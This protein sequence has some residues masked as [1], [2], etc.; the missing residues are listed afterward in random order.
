MYIRFKPRSI[1][2]L[3]N[4][5]TL[6]ICSHTQIVLNKTGC[7]TS[8]WVLPRVWVF[9]IFH[10]LSKLCEKWKTKAKLRKNRKKTIHQPVN[11]V[12]SPDWLVEIYTKY[13][14]LVEDFVESPDN[15]ELELP[16]QYSL[17]DTIEFTPYQVN[18]RG[19]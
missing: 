11:A 14:T 6:N 4:I 7:L 8:V 19:T 15:W 12:R 10:F 1:F 18:T 13:T 9:W 2:I 3:T 16:L 17:L 5:F